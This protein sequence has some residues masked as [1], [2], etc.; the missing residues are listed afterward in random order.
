M[1]KLELK[2]DASKSNQETISPNETPAQR[3]ERKEKEAQQM[4]ENNI[5]SDPFVLELQNRFGAQI[6]PGSV[7]VK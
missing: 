6:V 2:T 1:R 7:Q 4:A 5:A 3:A